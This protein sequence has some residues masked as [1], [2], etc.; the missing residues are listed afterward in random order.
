MMAAPRPRPTQ[1]QYITPTSLSEIDTCA[2]RA[3]FHRDP[4]T[5]YLHRSTP[6]S[7]LGSVAHGVMEMIGDPRGF[8][9]VWAEAAARAENALAAN[10]APAAP[11]SAENWPG[12]ALTKVRIRKVWQQ[13]ETNT[14]THP[15]GGRIETPDRAEP[16]PS[17]PWRERWLEHPDLPLAGRPDLV[18]RVDGSIWVLELKTG[19]QQAEPTPAQ[20]AQLL[21]YC[22]LVEANLGEMPTRAA[23][24]TT[25]GTRYPFVVEANEVQEVVRT[26][27][28]ALA[29]FNAAAAEG[30]GDGLAQPSVTNCAWC[31]F[32][33]ACRPFFER[34]DPSWEI[35]N[36]LLI[37]VDSIDIDKDRLHMAATV[38]RPDWRCNERV[39]LIGFPFR[40][41]PA[42]GQTWGAADFVGR[43]SSAVAAWNTTTHRW[44]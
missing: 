7:A 12:W 2:W 22:A 37:T 43:G 36:A 34:Y 5:S 38:A 26:A 1:L 17:L 23:V 20:K 10:W 13:A 11:P 42:P 30:L 28:A 4:S 3:G 18:R 8:D 21:L 39:D 24:K 6:A 40:T 15:V 27:L 35:A 32:R 19:L 16:H 44:T 41:T 25:R 9:A 14:K 31:P 29:E 33:V